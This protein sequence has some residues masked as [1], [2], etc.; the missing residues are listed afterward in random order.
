MCGPLN[1][2][3][4][5]SKFPFGWPGPRRCVDSHNSSGD[6]GAI[7]R[8]C[9]ALVLVAVVGDAGITTTR[10]VILCFSEPIDNI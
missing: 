10:A 7:I 2:Y 5:A 3:R 6:V 8:W 9:L 4:H 1:E